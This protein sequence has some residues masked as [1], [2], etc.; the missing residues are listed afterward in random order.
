ML[1]KGL[2]AGFSCRKFQVH[3]HAD[4]VDHAPLQ[5]AN[6]FE[7]LEFT[8]SLEDAQLSARCSACRKVRRESFRPKVSV[9]WPCDRFAGNLE[10]SLQFVVSSHYFDSM[11]IR[12]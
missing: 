1:A 5:K 7:K 12:G 2:E 10:A 8:R 6:P 4:D 3:L 9:S 11:M